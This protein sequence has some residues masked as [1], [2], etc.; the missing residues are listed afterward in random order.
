M[1][2]TYRLRLEHAAGRS[3]P[4]ALIAWSRTELEPR[5]V[6]RWLR[7]RWLLLRMT[8]DEFRAVQRSAT[9]QAWATR[10]QIARRLRHD[11]FDR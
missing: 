5:S 1:S 6:S 11:P 3:A 7:R 10:H 8:P 9:K 4:D 2:R